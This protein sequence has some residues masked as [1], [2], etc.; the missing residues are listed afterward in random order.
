MPPGE[1]GSDNASFLL[2]P[3]CRPWGVALSPRR[4]RTEEKG[5]VVGPEWGQDRIYKFSP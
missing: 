3:A 5:W 1:A 2:K 4:Q